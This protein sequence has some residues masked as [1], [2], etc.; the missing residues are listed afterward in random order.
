MFVLKALKEIYNSKYI[1]TVIG[2]GSDRKIFEKYVQKHNLNVEFLGNIPRNELSKY[3][4]S[5]DLFVF[6]SLHES[7]GMVVLEA[8]A[9]GLL[10]LVSAYG[11]PKMFVDDG[12]YVVSGCNINEMI[13]EITRIIND[14]IV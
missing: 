4:L 10:V 12:D 6:P 14:E 13:I 3:Y 1:L 11:G 9:H 2:D 7:G 5:S 8:K